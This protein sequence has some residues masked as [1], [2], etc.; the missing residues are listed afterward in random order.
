MGKVFVVGI[1]PGNFENMTIR[2]DRVLA[3][4]DAIVGYPVYVDLVKD[5]YPGK[6]L[7]ET[8]MTQVLQCPYVFEK[9]RLVAQEMA[10]ALALDLARDGK[11]VC[12]VCSGDSGIYGMAALVY[13]LR[14]ECAQ[15]EIEVVPGL[16]A[17]CS[18]GAVLGAPLTHDFAVISLSDRLTP[19]ETIEKR[20]LAAA[21]A[22]FSIAIYNP[23]SHGRPEHLKRACE[24]LLR[25]LPETRLCGIVRNIGRDGESR[26]ILTLGELRDAQADMF[27]TVFIANSAAKELSG[28]LVTPRGYRDV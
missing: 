13:E 10:D 3:A 28:N 17:A 4:C 25:V 14:G 18:G 1:G 2:A 24:I 21:S 20:L 6:A 8:P 7:F 27:C 26:R 12:I 9:A 22:D 15:P 5:R 23:V 16:T 19:W 11:Q